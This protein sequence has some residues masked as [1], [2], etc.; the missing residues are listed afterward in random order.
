MAK[1]ELGKER[2]YPRLNE[3][4]GAGEAPAQKGRGNTEEAELPLEFQ[5]ADP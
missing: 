5:D 1:V 2:N 4:S 3:V